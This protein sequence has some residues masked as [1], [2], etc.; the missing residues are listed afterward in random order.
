MFSPLKS[1]IRGGRCVVRGPQGRPGSL[2]DGGRL[3][4]LLQLSGGVLCGGLV[5][6]NFRGRHG[7]RA[8]SLLSRGAEGQG[9][10]AVK[11]SA[12]PTPTLRGALAGGVGLVR[13]R[14]RRH[15]DLQGVHTEGCQVSLLSAVRRSGRAVTLRRRGSFVSA[16]SLARRSC[17][18]CS[19][20]GGAWPPSPS[21]LLTGPVVVLAP[22]AGGS[23]ASGSLAPQCC[24]K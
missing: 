14:R 8:C 1:R 19:S 22:P 7:G 24:E 23:I 12:S 6:C 15:R 10:G 4:R 5:C 2:P 17:A 20:R 11:R 3:V 18:Q 21:P 13:R 16:V 9:G